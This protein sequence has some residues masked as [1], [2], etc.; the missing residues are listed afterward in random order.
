MKALQNFHDAYRDYLAVSRGG[1]PEHQFD[2]GCRADVYVETSGIDDPSIVIEVKSVTGRDSLAIAI[3]QVSHRYADQ[4]DQTEL[5]LIVPPYRDSRGLRSDARKRAVGYIDDMRSRLGSSCNHWE[6][7]T[8]CHLDPYVN[9]SLI[10]LLDCYRDTGYD[11]P[12]LVR[13]VAKIGRVLHRDIRWDENIIQL[14][15]MVGNYHRVRS[16]MVEVCL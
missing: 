16:T 15:R 1:I 8:G 4:C 13:H 9:P 10:T 5:H 12:S 3:D 2:N 7:V 14:D 11:S 6:I